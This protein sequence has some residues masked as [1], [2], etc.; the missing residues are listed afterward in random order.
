MI[1]QT[2]IRG[3]FT[4]IA[5]VTALLCW[6]LYANGV[7]LGQDLK[8]GTTLRFALDV[9]GARKAGRLPE[10]RDPEELVT[11][12]IAV[13]QNRVDKYGLAETNI[14]PLGENKFQIS[15]PTGAAGQADGIVN[16]VTQLGDLKFRIVARPA[17]D[18]ENRERPPARTDVWAQRTRASFDAFKKKELEFWLAAK[19]AGEPYKPSLERYR[20]VKIRGKAGTDVEDFHILEEPTDPIEK[21]IGGEIITNPAVGEDYETRKPNVVYSVKNEWQ[22]KFGEW[23][24]AA[25]G[26]DMAIVLNDEVYTAPV[27][28]SALT[29]SVQITLGQGTRSELAKEAKEIVT[30]LQTGSLKI[31]P[32]LEA[33]SKI[34]AALAGESRDRGILAIIVAFAL[35]LLFMILYYRGSGMVANFALLLNLVLLVG[36]LSFFSAV[37]TLPGIA[38]IVLTVGMAVDAN[39][40]INE[41]IREELRAGRNLRRALS[42]GYDRALS[43]IIDANVTSVITAI[44][45]YNFGTGPVRGFA[46]TLALGLLVSMFTAIYVTRTLFEWLISKGWIKELSM[47]GSGEPPRI[48]WIGMRR[49]FVP[50]SVLGVVFGLFMF[51]TTD[52]YTLYDVDFTGGF[53]LQTQF[54]EPTSV[55]EVK[56][57]LRETRDL[58]VMT[59]G[60][61]ANG[62]PVEKPVTVSIGGFDT[63]EVLTVGD[64]QLAA[65]IKVQRLFEDGS[66][67]VSEDGQAQAFEAFIRQVLKD[68]LRPNWQLSAPTAYAHESAAEDAD[69]EL[70]ALD[71]GVTM[72]IALADTDGHATAERLDDLLTTGFPHWVEEDGRQV[73]RKMSETQL[74]R[75]VVVRASDA[76]SPGISAFDLW[77]R[78]ANSEGKTVPQSPTE[79]AQRLSEYLGGE[80]FRRSL[81]QAV[82]GGAADA[83]PVEVRLST[84]FSSTDVIGTSVANRLKND[85]LLALLLSLIGIIIYIA[86][87]FRS[88]AMGF[89]AVLCLFHDV[90]IVLGLVAVANRLGLVDAK[91]NLAMVAAFLTLVG[92]SVNDTVVIFDRIREN[93]GKRPTIDKDLINLSIN[94]TLA[95]TI[96]TSVTFLLV[97]VA[98]F[99]FNYGQRN[100]LE[101]FS[102][103]LILGSF[104]GT[105][106]TVAISSPLLLYLPWLW[107][108]LKGFAPSSEMVTKCVTN[109]ALILFTP[110][111]A[112]L[113]AIWWIL[114]GAVALIIGIVR[115][116]PWAMQGHA[117]AA[118]TAIA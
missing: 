100:V 52:R 55:D 99:A 116:V 40:L 103:L 115:F 45:L 110:V 25:V 18:Y 30:V 49:M 62:D 31:Q 89:A 92:Y 41:R 78:T 53:R 33:Q 114:F 35:V 73:A 12:T 113:Y 44:F 117:E 48:D 7:K 64:G 98:L 75:H 77:L 43:A 10:G 95:R 104:I 16:I 69:E 70:A 20:L 37:L 68:R 13:I 22:R 11:E 60:Y 24:G 102:F 23:T 82:A 46:I 108:R 79:L 51:F 9:E 109:M 85:A 38:G 81:G 90:A 56:T 87:R 118:E 5:I 17:E 39:I 97:C 2:E 106:S 63:A 14:T 59:R 29:D 86:F 42:E 54:A 4:I 58:T 65:D 61:D 72:R 112:V 74:T 80:D 50:I 71:G 105:Y 27:I 34:G 19:R 28:N 111:A 76:P 6:A 8:G 21:K 26:L 66:H 36:F 91:I 57:A 15:L 96:K 107:E 1:E 3:R 67:E 88:R 47:W 101:G 32:H 94:Q 84:P 93:R 83:A